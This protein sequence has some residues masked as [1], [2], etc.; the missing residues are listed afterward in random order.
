MGFYAGEGFLYILFIVVAI[1]TLFA[2]F[3][4][5]STFEKYSKIM[6]SRGYTGAD[7]ARMLLER[8]G[9]TDVEVEAIAG[10]LTDH[11]DPT[12]KVIRLSQ[13]VYASNSVAALGVAAHETGHALQHHQGYVPLDIRS[14]IFPA[15]NI[16]SKL[17]VPLVFVG[18]LIGYFTNSL[19][20]AYAGILLFTFVVAFQLITLPVEFDASHRAMDMLVDYGFLSDNEASGAR[21]VLTAAALTYVAAAAASI[22]NLLRLIA[23]VNGGGRRRR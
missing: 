23:I 13:S 22:I 1:L 6:N 15:V 18:I 8:S 21:K 11:Y 2:Q 17:A 19:F 10:N 20:L 14:S 3:N 4:V 16:G 5:K 12:Q 9:I 7:V